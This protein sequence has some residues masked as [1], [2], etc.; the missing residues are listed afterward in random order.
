M[1]RLRDRAAAVRCKVG[2]TRLLD[3]LARVLKTEGVGTVVYVG[4]TFEES[5]KHAR[6]LAKLLAKRNIRLIILHDTTSYTVGGEGIFA[7]MARLTEG[8]V[9]PFDATAISTLRDMLAAVAVLA[10]GGT[11]MLEV[12]RDTMP[13][14][15]MLLEHLKG[16]M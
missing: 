5:E 7:E 4:D 1:N 3:I 8:A 10:V 14:A 12:K 16:D 2:P 6:K 9:L 15:R 11:E 13:A